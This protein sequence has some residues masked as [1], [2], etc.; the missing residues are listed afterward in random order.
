MLTGGLAAEVRFEDR[1]SEVREGAMDV[2][3]RGFQAEETVG[4][5]VLRHK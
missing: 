4:A 2:W 3:G 5:T 1:L